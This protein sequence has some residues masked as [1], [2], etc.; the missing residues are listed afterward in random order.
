MAAFGC[1]SIRN[2]TIN[3]YNSSA[4]VAWP[5]YLLL[6]THLYLGFHWCATYRVFYATTSATD[7]FCTIGCNYKGV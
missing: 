1:K 3:S 5:P 6:P 2:S 4:P 7:W